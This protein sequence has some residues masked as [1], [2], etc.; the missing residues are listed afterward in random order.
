MG[1][2]IWGEGMRFEDLRGK[3]DGDGVEEREGFGVGYD[4]IL[5]DFDCFFGG[6]DPV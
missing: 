6:R 2:G 4:L 3:G 5:S 1:N